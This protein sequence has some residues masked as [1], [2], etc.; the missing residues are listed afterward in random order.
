MQFLGD[1]LLPRLSPAGTYQV[2]P[3]GGWGQSENYGQCI[4]K[5]GLKLRIV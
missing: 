5:E 3:S 1:A 2:G 4:I